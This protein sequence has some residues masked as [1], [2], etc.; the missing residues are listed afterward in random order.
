MKR[1]ALL[2]SMGIAAFANAETANKNETTAEIAKSTYLNEVVVT[3]SK[4]QAKLINTPASIS[5]LT[6]KNIKEQGHKSLVDAL[7]NI[8]GMNISRSSSSTY[9][10]IRGQRSSM[11]E[12]PIIYIDGVKA[13]YGKG[14]S[15]NHKLD[16]I[17][18]TVI[19]RIEV[20]K[21]PPAS[22]YGAGASR[23]VINIYTKKSTVKDDAFSGQISLTAGSWDTT[24]ENVSIRGNAKKVDYSARL[25]SEKSDGYRETEKEMYEGEVNLGFNFNENNRL[26][27]TVGANKTQKKYASPFFLLD[28]LE[29][30]RNKGITQSSNG[31]DWEIPND[32]DNELKYLGLNY[33]GKFDDIDIKTGLNFSRLD[34]IYKNNGD[35]KADGTYKNSYREDRDNEIFQYNLSLSKPIIETDSIID[36]ITIG[37]DFEDYKFTQKR[38]Y[39]NEGTGLNIAPSKTSNQNTLDANN[40]R[41]GLFLNNDFTYEDFSILT[42][43][44]YDEFSYELKNARLDN[45]LTAT[46]NNKANAT[47]RNWSWDIAPSYNIT[48]NCSIYFSVSKSYWYPNA[49]YLSGILTKDIPQEEMIPEENLTHE[50]GIK[51]SLNENFNW[52]L[53]AFETKTKNKY[54]TKYIAGSY[55]GY[56]A[57]GDATF[58]GVE[59]EFEGKC[60]EY[61]DYRGSVS[62]LDATWD[63]GTTAST[64]PDGITKNTETDISGKRLYNIPVWQYTAGITLHPIKEISWAF[65]AHYSRQNYIDYNNRFKNDNRLTVDTKLTYEPTKSLEISLLCANLLDKEYENIFHSGGRLNTD[66]TFKGASYYPQ[67]GRYFEL[68]LAYKF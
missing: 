22:V 19:D 57:V 31:T 27:F 12:G 13:M 3:G 32:I 4:K 15:N 16:D 29:N 28:D 68:G 10:N 38:T 41:Y 33:K 66:G 64:Y 63:K 55:A 14:G 9:I 11:S 37:G 34:E 59:L 42:G 44:R 24:K 65:D 36:I 51:H 49:S 21:A 47:F 52:N 61:L 20:I 1:I 62:W 25:S 5:I 54:K 43:I 56:R 2:T 39:F 8:P 67:D 23:G 17:P 46:E 60:T 18:A 50:I 40:Q 26:G 7:R 45:E 53:T 48:E 6:A 35:L 58:K 30:N